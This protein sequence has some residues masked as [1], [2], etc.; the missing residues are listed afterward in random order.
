MV[1][2]FAEDICDVI[3][4]FIIVWL[5]SRE[6]LGKKRQPIDVILATVIEIGHVRSI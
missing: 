2:E 5:L 1:G 3:E 4:N 6:V